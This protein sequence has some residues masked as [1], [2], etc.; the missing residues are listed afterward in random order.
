MTTIQV[1]R[2]TTSE[3]VTSNRVLDSGEFG[4]DETLRQLKIGDG[5]TAWRSLPS[6][7]VLGWQ[8]IGSVVGASAV[9]GTSIYAPAFAALAAAAATSGNVTQKTAGTTVTAAAVVTGVGVKV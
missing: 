2:G 1:R 4:Y 8:G 6:I 3:W 5:T 7:G 9:T